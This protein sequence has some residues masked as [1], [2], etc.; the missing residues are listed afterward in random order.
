MHSASTPSRAHGARDTDDRLAWPC[1]PFAR[2]RR[3]FSCLIAVWGAAGIAQAA[4]DFT[5]APTAEISAWKVSW[6]DRPV[7]VYSFGSAQYKPYVK[8]LYAWNGVNILRDAPSDH[9]HHH[10]LMYAVRVNGLNFW[11]EVPG[12]GVQRV[13]KTQP[14]VARRNAAGQPEAVLAQTIHWVAPADAF[15]PDTTRAALLI[16]E[17]TLTVALDEASREVALRWQSEFTAGTNPVTLGGSSYFGLGMRFRKDFDLL[18]DH[19]NA[20]GKPD[21]SG[22]KQDVSRHPWGS[23]A[24]AGSDLPAMVVLY[25]HPGNARGDAHGR[26]GILR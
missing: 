24:F 25:G 21:L 18:A 26:R 12:S 22:S 2:I 16:E 7:M 17:R 20:G 15:L 9:L 10:A 11:E 6:G 19:L 23:V 14:P 4:P 5:F 13:V 1:P 3:A 8:E